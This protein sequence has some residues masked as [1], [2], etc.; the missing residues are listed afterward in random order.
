MD[1]KAPGVMGPHIVFLELNHTILMVS[2]ANL[3]CLTQS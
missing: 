3:P 2:T 1:K